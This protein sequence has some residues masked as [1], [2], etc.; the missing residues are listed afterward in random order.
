MNK[1]YLVS[2][3]AFSLLTATVAPAVFATDAQDTTPVTT[4]VAGG[5]L[6]ITGFG[7]F[8]GGASSTVSLESFTAPV[9]ATTYVAGNQTETGT[10]VRISDGTE[11]SGSRLRT[12]L[13]SASWDY[14]GLGNGDT[15]VAAT[16]TYL[17]PNVDGSFTPIEPTV[18]VST[19]NIDPAERG[20]FSF[21]LDGSYSAASAVSNYETSFTFPTA[22]S[23]SNDYSNQLGSTPS[24]PDNVYFR[25]TAAG[26]FE[27][28]VRAEQIRAR[29]DVEQA[30]GEYTNTLYFVLTDSGT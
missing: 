15:T 3:M 20:T 19:D 26:Y 17:T 6:T 4:E 22:N 8:T 23:A 27:G 18:S 28:E 24:D 5:D 11:I 12:Y 7:S 1:K 30:I 16:F 21:L 13:N 9:L 10:Y 29:F 14:S 25:S 2:A